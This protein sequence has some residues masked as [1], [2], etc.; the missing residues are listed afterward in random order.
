MRD[1]HALGRA[2]GARGVDD[3]GEGVGV[4]LRARHGLLGF[5]GGVQ[6]DHRPVERHRPGEGPLDQ[7]H[8]HAAVLCHEREPLG[9]VLRVQGQEGAAGAQHTDGG[10]HQVRAAFGADADHRLGSH[11]E[12]PQATRQLFGLLMEFRVRDPLPAVLDGCR[13][14]GAGGVC[15]D[16]LVQEQRGGGD[17]GAAGPLVEGGGAGGAGEGGTGDTAVGVGGHGLELGAVHVGQLLGGGGG[18]V[19]RVGVEGE[20]LDTGVDQQRE[21]GAGDLQGVVPGVV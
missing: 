10:A 4:G 17:E 12:P 5:R 8:P 2:G 19:F 21:H 9:G 11:P 6:V 14:R 20:G 16:V 15:G 13:V 7:Q 3:V 18:H 1:G